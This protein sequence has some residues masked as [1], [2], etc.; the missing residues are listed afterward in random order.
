MASI[1]AL[2]TGLRVEH[3]IGKATVDRLGQSEHQSS[4]RTNVK[5]ST[6]VAAVSARRL[7]SAAALAARNGS[8]TL[9][10]TAAALRRVLPERVGDRRKPRLLPVAAE[11]IGMADRAA[12]QPH[13]GAGDGRLAEIERRAAAADAAAQHHQAGFGAT[14]RLRP[15][16]SGELRPIAVQA[17]R[18]RP[19]PAPPS[20]PGGPLRSA[21]L[22]AIRGTFWPRQIC[23]LI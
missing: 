1:T 7:A 23:L 21:S 17:R 13:G 20:Q 2:N 16:A 9:A 10:S 19:A 22:L 12:G 18:C 14:Q 8:S 11:R 6:L 4:P 3:R 15:R 5:K